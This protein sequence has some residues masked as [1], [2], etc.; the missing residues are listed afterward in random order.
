HQRAAR[1]LP[2]HA[3]WSGADLLKVLEPAAAPG[4]AG[5]A[6]D[7]PVKDAAETLEELCA[8]NGL[9]LRG[10]EWKPEEHPLAAWLMHAELP[11]D[12]QSAYLASLAHSRANKA[13]PDLT[14]KEDALF[15]AA[16]A[17]FQAERG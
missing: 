13:M 4:R 9:G 2:D 6:V 3:R 5:R 12:V 11:P 7:D 1:R 8:Q 10:G 16:L 14:D 17:A 15:Q